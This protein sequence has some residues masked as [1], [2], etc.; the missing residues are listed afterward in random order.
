MRMPISFLVERHGWFA[1]IGKA[2]K[3]HGF[4][5]KDRCSEIELKKGIAK[6]GDSR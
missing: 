6:C 1:I 4:K 3:M 2:L 5:Q